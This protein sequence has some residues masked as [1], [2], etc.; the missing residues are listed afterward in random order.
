MSQRQRRRKDDRRK[1]AQARG[2]SKRQLAAGASLTI[3]ATLAA[4]GSAQAADFT[5]T[6]LND[7]GSGSLRQAIIDANNN[8]GADRVLFASGLS[9][10]ITLTSGIVEMLDPVQVLG[11]GAD[12]LTISGNNSS[13]VFGVYPDT[14]GNSGDPVTISGLT[15]ADGQV[16]PLGV[17]A[18]IESEG[19]NLTVSDAVIT[20]NHAGEDGGGIFTSNSGTPGSLTI[21]NSILS[22]NS[23]GDDGADDDAYGGAVFANSTSVTVI[24]TTVSGNTAGGDGGGIY[25]TQGTLANPLVVA[26]STISGNS[27]LGADL[28]DDAG[29]LWFCCGDFGE[30]MTLD[31]STISGNSTTSY[32]GGAVAFVQDSSQVQ[33]NNTIL[34]NN[35]ASNGPGP[36][37]HS[38]PSG[39]LAF[40][41]V[42][43]PAEVTP[44]PPLVQTGP[45]L[46]GVDPQLGPLAFNGGSTQTQALALTS[47]A[48]DAGN[49]TLT[50]DQRGLTRPFDFASRVNAAGGNGAD[51]GAF[52]LAPNCQGKAATIVA[53]AGQTTVGTAKADVIVGTDARDV[54]RAAKGNDRVC[55]RSGNDK[56]SGGNGK[57]RINGDKGKDKLSGQKGKDTAK[58]GKGKDTLRGGK[59]NDKLKGG[60]GR[61]RLIG[62]PGTDKLAGGAGKDSQKQ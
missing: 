18:G 25:T 54:I 62:G 40:S 10:T 55:A 31:S 21:R 38:D 53:R 12:Q 29:G 11:P 16:V 28:S 44:G 37:L 27:T 9:G 46:F 56:V 50:T 51:M 42:E 41:L 19:A 49:T 35:S 6:N 47:P 8:P 23:A 4:A 45:N 5:V 22:G 59:G 43:N 48:V 17:G 13:G 30:Q 7:S 57:D 39:Q 2:P 34:A 58:G 52:E 33:I 1:R 15:I 14:N 26:N 60:P 61:D 20:G 3:G 24:G 32:G 36:D